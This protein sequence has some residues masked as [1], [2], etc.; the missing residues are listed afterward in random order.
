MLNVTAEIR[1]MSPVQLNPHHS[2]GLFE[3]LKELGHLL[4]AEK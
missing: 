4:F 1:S 3:E 2:Q